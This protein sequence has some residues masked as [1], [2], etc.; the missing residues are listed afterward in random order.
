MSIVYGHS[1]DQTGPEFSHTSNAKKNFYKSLK[2]MLCPESLID[3][4]LCI[5]TVPFPTLFS[6]SGIISI[7]SFLTSITTLKILKRIII[8]FSNQSS[9]KPLLK[10]A[11]PETL[12]HLLH[13]SAAGHLHRRLSPGAPSRPVARRGST[14]ATTY[15]S[16]TGSRTLPRHDQR[17][18]IADRHNWRY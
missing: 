16:P 18:T 3:N 14:I 10:H 8:N 13:L 7:K 11:I 12:H 5:N 4:S 6:P 17:A 9:T 1:V 2:K 15:S